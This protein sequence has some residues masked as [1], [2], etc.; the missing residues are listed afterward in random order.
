VPAIEAAAWELDGL[1]VTIAPVE[2]NYAKQACG[3]LVGELVQ[4]DGGVR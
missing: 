2:R 4:E 3:A 1:L